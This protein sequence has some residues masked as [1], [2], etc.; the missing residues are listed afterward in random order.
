[1]LKN[2]YFKKGFFR[3]LNRDSIAFMLAGN[4]AIFQNLLMV[5]GSGLEGTTEQGA[6]Q[7]YS[8]GFTPRAVGFGTVNLVAVHGL[9]IM[10]VAFAIGSCLRGGNRFN[11]PK[12]SFVGFL[13]L[14]N[15]VFKFLL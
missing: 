11:F 6:A 4:T 2:F 3:V 5:F 1:M 15:K 14:K 9:G 13:A 7:S 10:A 8:P 12:T